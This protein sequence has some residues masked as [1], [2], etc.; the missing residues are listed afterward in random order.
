M[1]VKL[2]IA[3]SIIILSFCVLLISFYLHMEKKTVISAGEDPRMYGYVPYLDSFLYI[4]MDGMVLSVAKNT[5]D[6]I[7]IIE[8]LKFDHF[9]VGGCL[10]TRNADDFKTAARL[11]S[12]FEKYNPDNRPVYSIDISNLENIHLY[13]NSMYVTFGTIQN[14][15]VKIR[16]LKEII[17]KLRISEGVKGLLDISVIG[18]QYIFTILT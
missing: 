12:L 4:D 7:P 13:T 2:F 6:G 8:G 15:D 5:T 11:I 14:A 3:S 9:S 17:A 1:R 10:E 16:T 18:R